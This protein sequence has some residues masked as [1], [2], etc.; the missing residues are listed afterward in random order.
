MSVIREYFERWGGLRFYQFVSSEGYEALCPA[1]FFLG[2]LSPLWFVLNLQHLNSASDGGGGGLGL[3]L[4]LGLRQRTISPTPLPRRSVTD[5]MATPKDFSYWVKPSH[6][7]PLYASCCIWW[8][9]S[10][11]R[12][13]SRDINLRYQC[14]GVT[15]GGLVTITPPPLQAFFLLRKQ[16]TIFRWRKLASTLRLTQCDPPWKIKA[17]P[18][19]VWAKLPWYPITKDSNFYQREKR[20]SLLMLKIGKDCR[21]PPWR[22]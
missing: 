22:I 5:F 2:P 17:T 12:R 20:E 1:T 13:M 8:R 9:I 4:G 16:P 14:E 19:P 7:N 21:Q 18:L 6:F 3:G 10:F 15:G 11:V